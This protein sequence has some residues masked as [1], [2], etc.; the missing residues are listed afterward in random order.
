MKK[1]IKALFSKLEESNALATAN[2]FAVLKNL[3]GGKQLSEAIVVT[4]SEGPCNN[5]YTCS[6]SN[7]KECTNSG[8]CESSSN[9]GTCTNSGTC[10]F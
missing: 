7:T 9:S 5:T 10:F 2:G 4:N 6:G 1:S 3:R 8:K